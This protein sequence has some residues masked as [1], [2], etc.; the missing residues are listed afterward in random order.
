LWK[1]EDARILELHHLKPHVEKGENIAANLLVLCSKCHDA[2][3]AGR[4]IVKEEMLGN[5]PDSYKP[6]RMK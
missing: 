5:P 1:R 3:H 2:A 4:L 6:E